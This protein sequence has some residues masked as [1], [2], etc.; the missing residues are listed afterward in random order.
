[1]QHGWHRATRQLKVVLAHRLQ[2][3]HVL[4]SHVNSHAHNFTCKTQASS[5]QTLVPHTIPARAWV[6]LSALHV[7]MA[8]CRCL[9]RD[10]TVGMALVQLSLTH[11]Q[12]V[13]QRCRRSVQT[14]F[15]SARVTSSCLRAYCRSA[16]FPFESAHVHSAPCLFG[17]PGPGCLAGPQRVTTPWCRGSRPTTLARL[18]ACA[19]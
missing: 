15:H 3:L 12:A 17:R 6:A 14:R 19:F 16:T 10:T 18:V 13:A 2:R 5:H 7:L 4:E 1:V 11:V 9:A 8:L